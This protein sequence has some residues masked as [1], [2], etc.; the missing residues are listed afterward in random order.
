MESAFGE[1]LWKYWKSPHYFVPLGIVSNLRKKPKTSLLPRCAMPRSSV[2]WRSGSFSRTS[3]FG[4]SSLVFFHFVFVAGR[5]A[6]APRNHCG[7]R[8][9]DGETPGAGLKEFCY[10]S[11]FFVIFPSCYSFVKTRFCRMR[12]CP[13]S[14][15]WRSSWR[16]PATSQLL[17]FFRLPTAQYISTAQLKMKMRANRGQNFIDGEVSIRSLRSK[18]ARILGDMED[19]WTWWTEWQVT[20]VIWKTYTHTHTPSQQSCS[21]PLR[22][23]GPRTT[24]SRQSRSPPFQ[25]LTTEEWLQLRT[26]SAI[27]LRSL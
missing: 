25:F 9:D 27:F 21:G 5:A 7:A 3:F 2:L 13:I 11:L 26:F 18:D 10:S 23:T 12:W 20:W 4:V 19:G 1:R 22:S 6:G 14:F 16:W 15:G 24:C 17:P 8:R